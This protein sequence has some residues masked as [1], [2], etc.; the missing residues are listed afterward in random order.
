MLDMNEPHAKQLE[1][2][3]EWLKTKLG[4]HIK[5]RGNFKQTEESTLEEADFIKIYDLLE[6]Y[7]HVKLSERSKEYA[8]KRAPLYKQAIVDGD[9]K[10]FGEYMEDL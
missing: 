5:A 2:F 6:C 3:D 1:K 7:M 8:I 4:G 10:K 9:S